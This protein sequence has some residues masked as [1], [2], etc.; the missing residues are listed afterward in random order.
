MILRIGHS[1][2]RGLH[3]MFRGR[4]VGVALAQINHIM[5]LCNFPVHTLD[6]RSKKLLGQLAH[7]FS[8]FNFK[9]GIP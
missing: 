2:L 4:P 1:L 6:E 9:R 7:H 3:N 8:G 5:A